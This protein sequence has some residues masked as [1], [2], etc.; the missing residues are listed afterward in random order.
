MTTVPESLRGVRRTILRNSSALVGTSILTTSLGA[1]FW[2]LAA[3]EFPRSAVGFAS[4]AVSAMALLGTL[5][6]LGLGTFLMG[7][8]PRKRRTRAA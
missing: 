4:A 5:A 6:L 8:L 3:R 2:W 7:E 1:A